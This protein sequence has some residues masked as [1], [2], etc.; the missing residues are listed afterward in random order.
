VT[1]LH[2]E[3]RVDGSARGPLESGS[4]RPGDF[5]SSG[6]DAHYAPD[7]RLE[8]VHLDIAIRVDLD[9]AA[10]AGEVT[11]RV[12]ANVEGATSLRLDAVGFLDLEV[13]GADHAY[14][15]ERIDLVFPP[16]AKDEEREV[17]ISYRVEKPPGG[18]YVST[19]PRFAVTDHETE[20]AR[21][22]LP[23]VDYPAV[24][25]T[26]AFHIRADAALTILAS[27]ARKGEDTHDDGTKTVH[28]ELEQ[29]CPSY[30][31]CFAI[32]DFV[33]WE[34]P[35]VDGIPTAVYGPADRFTAEQL[36]LSF[37]RI[38]DML[39]WVP[40][41]L[42][43][44]FPYPKYFQFAVPGIGGAMENVSLTSWDDRFVLDEALATEE[45][46]L[47]DVIN[48]HELAHT[49]FGDLVVCR[50]YAHAWLK[51][52]WATYMETNWLAHD[53]GKDAGDYD[54][55]VN[56]RAYLKEAEEQYQRPIV[57]RRFDSSFDMYDYHLYPG[58]AWRI[59]MLRKLLGEEVFWPA[60]Q[61]YLERYAGGVVE[62]DA[63]RHVL[64]EHSG[65]SLAR[66]FDQW[67]HSPGFPKLAGR[68]GW[69]ATKKEGT[70]SL[71][72]KQIDPKKGVGRFDFDLQVA[73]WI[74][75]EKHVGTLSFEGTTKAQLVVPMSADPERVRV[76]PDLALLHDLDFEA[77]DRR[78]RAQLTRDD[79]FGRIQAGWA[80]CKSGKRENV[81]AVADAFASEPYWGVRVQ[82]AMALGEAQVEAAVEGLARI[83]REHA[84]PQV[85]AT[86]F[87]AAGRYR[88]E[89]IRGALTARLEEELPPRAK[90]ALLEALGAQRRE[91]PLEVLRTA[92][93]EASYGGFAQSGALR[94][95][96]ATRDE[97]ALETILAALRGDGLVAM[98]HQAALAAGA[99]LRRLDRRPREAAV[100]ALVDALRDPN[101]R[102]RQG[103]AYGLCAGRA[104]EALDAVERYRTTLPLQEQTRLDRH[105]RLLRN[106]DRSFATAEKRIEEL[107]QKLRKLDDRLEKLES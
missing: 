106:G 82:W 28:W 83:V 98:R 45:Q 80:L 13:R 75:G 103:A 56:A 34:G 6:A 43:V 59:H 51:E 104:R 79:V 85:M 4:H 81:A 89:R 50:D 22:W 95:L 30:L 84:D 67:L 60:V 12:R 44:P 102:V 1:I 101:A 23:C 54:L 78:W 42:G 21:Y 73:W 53:R 48:L 41:R 96:A 8:T 69:N 52:G 18:L 37:G 17:T 93:G 97:G 16:F 86:L 107:E 74:D 105:L 19:S 94:G 47:L 61:S 70:F 26:L 91:A 25:P 99:L 55:W 5:H 11:H 66:F 32:G 40:E 24:R 49:W 38:G 7:L 90:E 71:E 46:Q 29:R 15:G 57:T 87:K 72:Q 9:A 63:F 10:L 31:T 3:R 68:F 58:A 100:D 35:T 65:R 77:G 62:T 39:R 2:A 92:A 27:G 76:D 14:D 88:D 36:E 33:C 64:E 20:R